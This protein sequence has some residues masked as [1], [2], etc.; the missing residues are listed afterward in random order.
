MRA[1][2]QTVMRFASIFSMAGSISILIRYFRHPVLQ[3]KEVNKVI[4]CVAICDFF[5][6]IGTFIGRPNDGTWACWIQSAMTTY[7]SLV[8]IFWTT[9][10]AF[11]L[12]QLVHHKHSD[13]VNC[14]RSIKIHSACWIFPLIM[15]FAPLSTNTYGN[16]DGKL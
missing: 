13:H 3:Q 8:S 10:I 6:S 4:C 7:F 9:V 16:P 15:T 5:F 14:F 11:M 2:L 1:S 12:Y